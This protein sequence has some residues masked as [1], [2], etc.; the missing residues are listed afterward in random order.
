MLTLKYTLRTVW[1]Y[2]YSAIFLLVLTR[3]TNGMQ[4]V[5][6][7]RVAVIGAGIGGAA[8]SFYLQDL[9]KNA[10]KQPATITAYETRNY[11]GGRLKH[12]IFG[13]QQAKIEVGGAAWTSSN[14]FMTELARRMNVSTVTLSTSTSTSAPEPVKNINTDTSV[15]DTIFN[16]KH[17]NSRLNQRLG[18]WR[19]NSFAHVIDEMVEHAGSVLKVLEAEKLF[20]NSTAENY[21]SSALVP[22]FK[23]IQD[24]IAFGNL[25]QFTNFTMLEYF[26][27]LGVQTAIIEDGLVPLNRAIY[28]QNDNSSAF[29]VFGSLTAMLNQHDVS[30]GNSDLVKTLFAAA[31]ATV[32][33]NTA[34]KTV[35]KNMD[36]TYT[37]TTSTG[38]T[39]EFDVVIIAAPLEQTNITF[40]NLNKMPKIVNRH[41][42]PWYVSVV[43]ADSVN[44]AQFHPYINNSTA[45][46]PPILLTNAKGT[47]PSTPWVCIQPVGKHGKNGT[48]NKDV[49]MVYSDQPLNL[50]SVFVNP[51]EGWYQQYWP[52]TFAHLTPTSN[53]D[54]LQPIV[55]APGLYNLNALESLASAMEVSSIAAKNGARLAYDFLY[56]DGIHNK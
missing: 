20:L 34:V 22:P 12:I 15:I 40:H 16:E 28:N 43:E 19:G 8:A 36:N 50:T 41:F 29:S 53:T 9:L 4:S 42:Y 37:L 55:L 46:L 47:T 23:S 3:C 38:R 25:E 13:E 6:P 2:Y 5:P 24:F 31:P 27:T 30:T 1:W 14:Q 18:V 45:S 7:P 48:A 32:L 26:S 51:K 39:D 17:S 56:S 11:I 35:T 21:R 44:H 49:F 10:T 33:L 52:Y 54:M